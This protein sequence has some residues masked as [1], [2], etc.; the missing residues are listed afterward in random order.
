[1]RWVDIDKLAEIH[2]DLADWEARANNVLNDLRKEVEDAESD[3]KKAGLDVVSARKKTITEGL[4][5]KSR[6]SIWQELA[7]HLKKLRNSKCWYSESPN[8]GSDKDVDHFRPKKAV[9]ED[10]EHE[11]Y[12]WLAF[13]W[14]NYRYSCQW[15][16]QR[17][18][19]TANGTDGGKLNHFPVSPGSFRARQEVDN[20]KKEEVEL[21]DPID[22]EDWKLL[23]F[24]P[25]GY[26]IP[27]KPSGTREHD[28]AKISIQIYHL[29]YYDFVHARK[30]KAMK[31]RLLI[32]EMDEIYPKIDNQWMKL[33]YK[34]RQKDLF[35]LIHPDSDYSAA[36]L[37]YARAEIYK[38]ECGHQVKREWLEEILN[39]NP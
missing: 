18:V 6:Q 27:A 36:A 2:P 13:S 30:A 8:P 38:L 25:N 11:G 10:P 26:P 15:C 21:L 17:R 29:H 31:V 23:T 5:K 35:R 4:G 9:T 34:E 20:W 24:L 7:P 19:D 28:R 12:W 14:I 1:M 32:Q 16:N 3:A 22:P 37:A 33:L 39:S